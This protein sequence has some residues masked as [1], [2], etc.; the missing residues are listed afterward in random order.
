[1][2]PLDEGSGLMSEK[3]THKKA[4]GLRYIIY[5]RPPHPEF[6]QIYSSRRIEE[7]YYQAFIW[8]IGHSHVVT[9][10]AGRHALVEVLTEK[11]SVVPRKGIVKKVSIHEPG[12]EKIQVSEGGVISY[13]SEFTFS[14]C[15]AA[16]Y[17]ERHDA[18][19]TGSFD[20][21]L[22]HTFPEESK[23]DLRPFTLVDYKVSR[24]RLEV[25]SVNAY[26]Q[27]LTLVTTESTF[28]I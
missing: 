23:D 28:E 14:Q 25:R 24:G 9:L 18:A 20:Q 22:L 21:R 19:F 2:Q 6:F 3:E 7:K 13:T 12:L 5:R 11:G 16:T 10:R 27:D 4:R 26:P 17:R 1:M 15:T 8:V